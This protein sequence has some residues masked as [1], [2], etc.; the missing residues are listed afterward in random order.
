[1]KTA[2]RY[3]GISS[4]SRL[5]DVGVEILDHGLQDLKTLL[6]ESTETE[7]AKGIYLFELD[8]TKVSRQVGL[9]NVV[10]DVAKGKTGHLLLL[11]KRRGHANVGIL[12]IFLILITTNLIL[13][14]QDLQTV[15]RETG[16]EEQGDNHG[17]VWGK[18]GLKREKKKRKKKVV[19]TESRLGNSVS[20]SYTKELGQRG[21]EAPCAFAEIGFLNF[22]SL[23]TQSHGLWKESLLFQVVN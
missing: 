15:L 7:V 10:K 21:K 3:T 11:Q 4:N 16:L 2:G 18:I 8:S 5:A 12:S 1:M 6:K 9:P 17:D 14:L 22:H 20:L 13:V 19:N 23:N